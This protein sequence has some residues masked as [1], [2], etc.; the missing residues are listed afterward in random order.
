MKK[1]LV[2]LLISCFAFPSLSQEESELPL[3]E[4]HKVKT[5]P[6]SPLMALKEIRLG[7]EFPIAE[8]TSSMLEVTVIDN[9]YLTEVFTA[10][11]KKR[12]YRLKADVRFVI[13]ENERAPFYVSP[14]IFYKYE[15]FREEVWVLRYNN[16]FQQVMD[17]DGDVRVF[18]TNFKIGQQFQVKETNML[19]EYYLGLGMRIRF[20]KDNMP[21]DVQY[22]NGYPISYGGY[23]LEEDRFYPNVT[24]GIQIGYIFK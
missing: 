16:L 22:L 1:L 14:E 7:Y 10:Y 13:N 15:N 9:S 11:T 20:E 12:G 5:D 8:K 6:L 3:W 2:C 21:A 24:A 19:F 17:F 4:Y 18:S 23:E